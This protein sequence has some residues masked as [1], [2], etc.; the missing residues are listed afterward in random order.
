MN[1][2]TQLAERL[3]FILC[4]VSAIFFV[5]W[6]TGYWA[7]DKEIKPCLAESKQPMYMSKGDAKLWAAYL[8]K[9]GGVK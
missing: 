6:E 5:G 7:R 3:I 8:T 1:R 2:S 4:F 9:R